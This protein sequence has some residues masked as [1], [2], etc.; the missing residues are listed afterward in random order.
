MNASAYVRVSSHSQD[1]GMQRHAIQQAAGA[2][3]DT[4]GKWYEDR[5]T[6][7]TMK[8]TALEQLRAE[9]RAGVVRKLYVYRLDR[10]TRTGI[11]DTLTLVDE[12]H[13]YGCAL[14]TIADGFDVDG[15]FAEVVL[16]VMAW[17]AKMERLAIGE[18]IQAA[19]ARSTANGGTW[20]RPRRMTRAELARARELS[21]GGKTV[22]QIA[23][24]LKVPRSTLARWLKRPKKVLA[25]P[26]RKTAAK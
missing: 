13:S 23:V 10:L 16:A 9:A 6:G 25:R 15:P 18:R 3:G 21:A 17:A 20:G 12:L 26:L 1:S 8:R 2:R 14:A 19:R 22:R 5:I 4:I 24:A 7:G 11:R